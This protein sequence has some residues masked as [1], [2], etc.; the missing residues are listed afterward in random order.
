VRWRRNPA[1]LWRIAPGYLAVADT[2]GRLAEA[3]G[4]A[5]D[6]WE[7][8]AEWVQESA[9]VED[10]ERHFAAEHET[11]ARDVREFLDRMHSE[12]FVD[13]AE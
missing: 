4:P 12:G 10:L 13:A 2:T 5:A 11:I 7:R 1:T 9:L 6:V 8:L 3:V